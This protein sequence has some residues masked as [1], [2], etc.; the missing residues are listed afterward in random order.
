MHKVST[1]AKYHKA[2]ITNGLAST[3]EIVPSIKEKLCALDLAASAWDK[4]PTRFGA[5]C[6]KRQDDRILKHRLGA[7]R[8]K[9]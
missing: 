5:F 2:K 8:F 1:L 3:S 7:N 9:I 4:A 6:H